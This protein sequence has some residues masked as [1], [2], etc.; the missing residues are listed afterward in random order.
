[1]HDIL[2]FKIVQHRLGRFMHEFKL[3]PYS[4][5]LFIHNFYTFPLVWIMHQYTP[6][7]EVQN[8]LGRFM[9][10]LELILHSFQV[11]H[12]L[13]KTYPLPRLAPIKES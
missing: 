6:S 5:S 8:R 1:M 9:Y 4:R 13:I 11:M 10:E 12:D 3:T 2:P 7:Q